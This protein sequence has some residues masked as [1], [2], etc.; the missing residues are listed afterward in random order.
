MALEE[1]AA[2]LRADQ[3]HA[4]HASRSEWH[5][6][7][8]YW[9]VL[10][11]GPAYQTTEDQVIAGQEV[12]KGYWLVPAKWYKLVQTSQRAYVLLKDTIQLNVNAMLRLPKPIE[13]EQ[14]KARKKPPAEP[15]RSS[16]RLQK[17]PPPQPTPPPSQQ[18]EKPKLL[19]EP[20]HNEILA[21]LADVR[22]CT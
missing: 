11:T 6:E 19:G 1:F 2:S 12:A 17:Q 21:S 7:G 5:I 9:L 14:V 4:V 20:K 8:S 3:V 13:F 22:L 15:S 18:R 16:D 10:I